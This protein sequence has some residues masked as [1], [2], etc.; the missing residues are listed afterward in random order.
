MPRMQTH[1]IG[2]LL[3]CVAVASPAPMYSP[4]V[5]AEL[6]GG[7]SNDNTKSAGTLRDGVLTVALVGET[8]RW[9]PSPD[10]APPVVTQLFGEEGKAPSNPGPLLRMPLGTR[11]VVR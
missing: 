4:P 9:Y 3:L 5:P 8:A 6:R 2:A 11:I 7:T 1:L 10:S